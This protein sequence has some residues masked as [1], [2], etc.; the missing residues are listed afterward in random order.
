METKSKGQIRYEQGVA[1]I[2]K[3]AERGDFT[4]PFWLG[5]TFGELLEQ[6]LPEMTTSE[7]DAIQ[8]MRLNAHQLGADLLADHGRPVPGND[9]RRPN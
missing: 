3:R 7:R 2:Q 9:R 6:T 4:D 1:E 5:R 8:H